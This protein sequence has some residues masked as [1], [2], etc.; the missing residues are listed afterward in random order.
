VSSEESPADE[1]PRFGAADVVD[2]VLDRYDLGRTSDGLLIAIPA[3]PR[4]A[5]IA[6]ELGTLRGEILRDLFREQRISVGRETIGQAIETLKGL[7]EEAMTYRVAIRAAQLGASIHVDLGDQSG[8]FVEVSRYGWELRDPREEDDPDAA[9]PVFRRTAATVALP[10][11]EKG[12]S[13][14]EMRRLLGFQ[15]ADDPRFRLLWGW[16]VAAVFES[17]P[18]PILWALGTQGSGKSTRARMLLSVLDPADRLGRE[19]GKNER[20]D[21]TS[22]RS[23]FLP[24]WDNIGSIS[25]A[26]SDWLCRLV[27]GVQIDRRALYTDDDVRTATLQRTGV[28]TSII[29][30]SGL[31]A[32]ALERLVLVEF[33]RIADRAREAESTLWREFDEV[34]PRILGALLD[35]VAG[36]LRYLSD[37]RA[38]RRSLPR[39]ADYAQILVALDRHLGLDEL[40]GYAATYAASVSEVLSDA[41]KADPLTAAVLTLVERGGGLWEGTSADL[42]EALKE[43]SPIDSRAPWPRTAKGMS[44][45]LKKAAEPLRATGVEVAG[46]K[47]NRVVNGVKKSTRLVTLTAIERDRQRDEDLPDCPSVPPSSLHLSLQDADVSAGESAEGDVSAPKRDERDSHAGGQSLL[48]TLREERQESSA[49][50]T[51]REPASPSLSSLSLDLD[52]LE[53][54]PPSPEHLDRLALNRA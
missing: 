16:L 23:R 44:D 34:H 25:A 47:T 35:D 50:G 33:E 5:K 29:L 17:V 40:D 54:G 19:P 15:D 20:D 45:A 27:T 36:V 6:R 28:A 30:P 32:D 22:A 13:R 51:T 49:D 4:A 14:D 12:G 24:S 1:K 7:A 3:N 37:V 21:S 9:R 42:V 11:P 26:T 18:R 48:P 46:R 10:A 53:L 43:W 38:E 8:R 2:F 31:G 52:D 41:A 39:M